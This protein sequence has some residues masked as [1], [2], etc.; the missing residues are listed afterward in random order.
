MP[1]V[2]LIKTVCD[3]ATYQ[4]KGGLYVLW[5]KELKG[6][7]LRVFPGGKKQFIV[8]YRLEGR[9]RFCSIGTYPNITLD[10]A[11]RMAHG[12][13]HQVAQGIDVAELKQ[14]SRH[15]E[16][17]HDLFDE[18]MERHMKRHNKPLTVEHFKG[19]LERHV[20][21]RLGAK[22]VKHITTKD[23]E[24]L[25]TRMADTPVMFNR[26][27]VNLRSLF[28]KAYVWSWLPPEHKNPCK[29]VKLF[30]ER[31]RETWCK[32]EQLPALLEAI[33][34]CKSVVFRSYFKFLL[35]TG[36]RRTEAATLK[37]E[38]INPKSRELC[39]PMTKNGRTHT[40]PLNDLAWRILQD[41]PRTEGNPFV[42]WS[43]SPSGHI[44]SPKQAWQKIRTA[45]GLPELTLHDLR[46]TH[47]SL[48]AISGVPLHA[49]G[50][51]LN[52]SDSS[53]TKIY[54]RLCDTYM[55]EVENVF[56]DKVI[57]ITAIKE[58]KENVA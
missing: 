23:I 31:S 51:I 53:S 42:F 22:M 25:K 33:D 17:L 27:L 21:P 32:P 11:R 35:Y 48:L 10:N 37:W 41:L 52:H 26:V 8:A 39:L 58:K 2:K 7:G 4:G 38:Y 40:L 44:E 19:R 34:G 57:S 56:A 54:S 36:L 55:Q 6:F 43:D 18:Y 29:G 1:A 24:D 5:D 9:K 50:K 14:Q 3:N 16:N 45:A 30:R 46:R 49:I 20:L 13:F 12:V 47:G 15:G 28:G